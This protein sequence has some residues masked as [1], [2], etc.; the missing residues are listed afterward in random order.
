MSGITM[1]STMIYLTVLGFLPSYINSNC[2][3][4]NWQIPR[5]LGNNASQYSVGEVILLAHISFV[6]IKPLIFS[7]LYQFSL[8][9]ELNLIATF[10]CDRNTFYYI[11]ITNL[12]I[13]KLSKSF[14]RA[15][16]DIGNARNS[17]RSDME[18]WRLVHPTT[19]EQHFVHRKPNILTEEISYG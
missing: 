19:T 11:P 16:L 6:Q 18:A 14:A 12:I 4:I 7:L 2:K 8:K 5:I 9:T 13:F 10:G 15:A 17:Y 1:K 3:V